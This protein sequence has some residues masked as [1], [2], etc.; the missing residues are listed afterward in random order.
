NEADNNAVRQLLLSY[1][2]YRSA[3]LRMIWKYLNHDELGEE[4]DQFRAFLLDYTAAM[5]LCESSM[6]FVHSFNRSP[7][8]IARLNEGEPVWGIPSGM[9]DTI[10]KNL[11][12]ESSIRQLA[13]A[14]E[15]YQR[16]KPRF[17]EFD[18]GEE[19]ATGEFHTAIREANGTIEK[20]GGVR[21]TQKFNVASKDLERLLSTVRYDTQSAVST[22]IGDVKIREPREGVSLIPTEHVERLKT[23]LKPGDVLIERR[24]WYV[25]NA[26]LPGYWPHAALYVGTVEDLK[27][28]GLENDPYVQNHIAK[29]SKLDLEG[30]PHVIIEAMSEGVVFSSLEHSIGGGDSAA[31]LRPQLSDEEKRE[32]IRMAFSHAGKPYDFEFDF[33]SHDKLVCTEVVYRAYGANQ[34]ELQFPIKQIMGRNTMPAIEMVGK[35]KEERDSGEPQFE[36]VAF[37]DGDEHTGESV[38]LT[39][40][41]K[42]VATLDR[43]ALTLFQDIKHEPI[44][45]FGPFGWALLAIV[46]A[47]SVGNLVY[48]ARKPHRKSATP[49]H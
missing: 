12:S 24:N 19:S 7:E 28:M 3:L 31:V 1:I 13:S 34:S 33:D 30:H 17:S 2:N 36:L 40:P 37:I 23:L 32:A 8:T 26:F 49:A 35:F 5:V 45:G 14:G 46:V 16:I 21:W 44:P 43:P 42:F 29:F 4:K 20:L 11:A 10:Q 6:K 15:Y 48:Y 41:E 18:L 39:D 22:W 25:S 38:F 27:A 9:Y 47:F